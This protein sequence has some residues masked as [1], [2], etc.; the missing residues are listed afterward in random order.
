MI[1]SILEGKHALRWTRLSCHAFQHNAVRLQLHALAYNLANF[2]RSLALPAEVEHW[3]LTMLREKLVPPG[4]KAPSG[5]SLGAAACVVEP[6][7]RELQRAGDL[8]QGRFL[9]VAYLDTAET[10]KAALLGSLGDALSDSLQPRLEG[11]RIVGRLCLEQSRYLAQP[12]DRLGLEV[13][14]PASKRGLQAIACG[15]PALE[16]LKVHANRPDQLI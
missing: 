7:G 4:P 10:Q 2:L 16:G 5:L 8:R 1:A 12:L 11:G 14:G 3:S 13:T 9:G 6:L 15:A